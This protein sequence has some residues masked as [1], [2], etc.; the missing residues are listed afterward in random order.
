MAD[1]GFAA[2]LVVDLLDHAPVHDQFVDK[3]SIDYNLIYGQVTMGIALL[4]GWIAS[5][6]LK[7]RLTEK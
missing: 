6:A 5:I 3:S 7:L 4:T 2:I 1:R